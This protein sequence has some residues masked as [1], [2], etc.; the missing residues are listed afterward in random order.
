[1]TK[2]FKKKVKSKKGFS[3]VESICGVMI[4]AVVCVGVLNSVA[5]SREMIYTNNAR[6]KASDKAQLVADEIVASAT[7]VDPSGGDAAVTFIVN[8]MNEIANTETPTGTPAKDIQTDDIGKVYYMKDG[9][10]TP[11]VDDPD[12]KLIQ[13]TLE[14]ITSGTLEETKQ[15]FTVDGVDLNVDVRKAVQAGWKIKI[16]VFY[17]KI[18]GEATYRTVD[19]DAFAAKSQVTD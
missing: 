4:L 6:E 13:Y 16:R 18:G 2:F 8:K 17:G 5:F 9:F 11:A 14:P 7:G 1:M 15:K 12:P 10:V 3:L 19:F